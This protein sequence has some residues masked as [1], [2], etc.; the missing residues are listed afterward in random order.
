[1]KKLI[2]YLSLS[3]A[4]L[5]LV[6]VFAPFFTT[7][8][9]QQAKAYNAIYDRYEGSEEIKN[10]FEFDGSPKLSFE[11]DGCY[12]FTYKLTRTGGLNYKN[13]YGNNSS[14]FFRSQTSL[15]ATVADSSFQYEFNVRRFND[16][17]NEI[18]TIKRYTYIY[19]FC[20]NNG[21]TYLRRTITSVALDGT[22]NSIDLNVGNKDECI[23]ASRVP[24]SSWLNKDN[25]SYFT[26]KYVKDTNAKIESIGIIN[27]DLYSGFETGSGIDVSFTVPSIN[28]KYDL[29]MY[30]GLVGMS[31]TL[32]VNTTYTL[33]YFSDDTRDYSVYSRIKGIYDNGDLDK[34]FTG[35]YYN[36]AKSIL[37]SQT[38]VKKR[39]RYLTEVDGTPFAMPKEEVIELSL[40]SSSQQEIYEEALAK[41]GIN[42]FKCLD[43]YVNVN[44]GYFTSLGTVNDI[45][46]LSVSYLKTKWLRSIDTSGKYYDYYLGLE[47]YKDAYGKFVGSNDSDIFERGLYEQYLNTIKTNFPKLANFADTQLYG[48]FG[49]VVVPKTLSLNSVLTYFFDI[50]TSKA[51]VLD[52]RSFT[53]QLTLAAYNRLL[54]EY[55]YSWLK[56]AW[57]SATEAIFGQDGNANFYMFYS[58]VGENQ[59][60]IGEN[61]ADDIEDTDGIVDEIAKDTVQDAA[62]KIDKIDVFL[63]G[64]FDGI[65]NALTGIFGSV[66]GFFSNKTVLAALP[67]ILLVALGVFLF[68]KFGGLSLFK[69][70]GKSSSSSS[71]SKKRGKK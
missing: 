59:G 30:M 32:P 27:T 19:D 40:L 33:K 60:Y 39:I 43:S 8:N 52:L 28:V 57:Y 36:K 2:K 18:T 22:Q 31:S 15:N 41:L 45:E 50:S 54:G 34:T 4:A 42:T 66:T 5:A 17:G 70:S 37:D 23:A 7:R 16:S 64:A 58:D 9:M 49:F 20:V 21:V 61:G 35:S 48:Y 62:E 26:K 29:R 3:I 46:T 71:K 47:S 63:N 67:V 53:A 1:M 11:S 25:L 65:L 24:D 38:K 69:K 14:G 6:L 12:R 68:I 55:N 13:L 10:A 44:D 56:K 51:N